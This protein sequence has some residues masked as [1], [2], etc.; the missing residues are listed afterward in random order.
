MLKVSPATPLLSEDVF[1]G[2]GDGECW[3]SP[4]GLLSRTHHDPTGKKV[5]DRA[6][7]RPGRLVDSSVVAGQEF[8]TGAGQIESSL[9]DGEA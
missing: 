4:L 2:F 7:R 6:A 3:N 5:F 1:I 9:D 8:A